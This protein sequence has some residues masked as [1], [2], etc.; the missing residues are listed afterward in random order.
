VQT[1]LTPSHPSALHSRAWPCRRTRTACYLTPEQ[2]HDGARAAASFPTVT[3]DRDD[4]IGEAAPN[5]SCRAS[6]PALSRFLMCQEEVSG[7]TTEHRVAQRNGTR[8][9]A[10]ETEAATDETVI[11]RASS[12]AAR[13]QPGCPVDYRL[14]PACCRVKQTVLHCSTP[15]C[16]TVYSYG[17][18]PIGADE[19]LCCWYAP[20]FSMQRMRFAGTA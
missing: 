7:W 19:V 5:P 17:R 9:S 2:W 13:A 6:A 1:D 10:D 15:Q 4:G 3:Y 20:G 16:R 14:P 11:G 12:G 18:V 8:T